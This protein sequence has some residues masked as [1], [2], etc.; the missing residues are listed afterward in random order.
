MDEITVT[1]NQI[2]LQYV[3]HMDEGGVFGNMT[4]IICFL[5]KEPDGSPKAAQA[6]DLLHNREAPF[7]MI[8]PE[9][10]QRIMPMLRDIQK[11]VFG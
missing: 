10:R 11:N 8:P 3:E 4:D 2:F 5:E 6:Y 1:M 7:L 9:H